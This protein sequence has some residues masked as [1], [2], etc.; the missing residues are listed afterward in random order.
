M[1]TKLFYL[2]AGFIALTF[3]ACETENSPV[4]SKSTI[5][6]KASFDDITTIADL[7]ACYTTDLTAGQ[8]YDAGDINIYFDLTNV[9]VEYKTSDN[10]FIKKTHLYVGNCELIPVNKR[11]IPIPGRFPFQSSFPN[12]T[13][14]VVYSINK[15]SLPEC[16]CI[17]AHSEVF[18]VENGEEVQSETAWGEGTRFVPS[19][20][21]MFFSV[22]QSEC[23]DIEE[24]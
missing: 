12:G 16:F 11:G 24:F 23:F 13:Q 3:T 18:R 10:W 17:S 4:S 21:S 6:S 9:Y 20:W 7:T 14:S 19:N 22:C 15:A 1:K 5:Q 8:H 2:F